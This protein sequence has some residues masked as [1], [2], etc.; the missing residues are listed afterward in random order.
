MRFLQEL[1][2]LA[3][4][5][6]AGTRPDLSNNRQDISAAPWAAVSFR[7]PIGP[8]TIALA[9][10][11]SNTRADSTYFSMLTPFAYLSA[12][13]ALDKEPLTY[14]SGDKWELN[15]LVLLYPDAQPSPTLRQRVEAW[16]LR[17]L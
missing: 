4:H 11:P 15:Y 13:Q 5:S 8:A 1:D 9:G 16:R 7:A 6:V 3:V 14:H 17:H 2:P 12:T 10:H